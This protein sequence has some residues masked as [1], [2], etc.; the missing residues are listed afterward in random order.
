MV[1]ADK[2]TFTRRNEKCRS[3]R[4]VIG[5]NIIVMELGFCWIWLITDRG[6]GTGKCFAMIRGLK[7]CT[8][9]CID[10]DSK[11]MTM[12]SGFNPGARRIP[13]DLHAMFLHQLS[14]RRYTG[15]VIEQDSMNIH[16]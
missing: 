4:D 2:A 11:I 10:L 1:Q 8:R 9:W 16:A 3:G 7:A 14:H 15:R 12:P 6:P 5:G 13:K